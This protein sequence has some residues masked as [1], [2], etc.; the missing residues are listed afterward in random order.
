MNLRKYTLGLIAGATLLSGCGDDDIFGATLP[1]ATDNFTMFALTGNPPAYPAGLNTYFRQPVR[2]DGS[3]AF[4]VAFDLN[5]EGLVVIYPVKLVVSSLGGDRSVGIRKV[6]GQWNDVTIAPT[7]V[8]QTD[9]AVVASLGEV[10][11]IEANRGVG[12]DVCSF[13]LSPN[14]YTKLTVD[15][16]ALATRTISISTVVNPNCGFRSFEPGIPTR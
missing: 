2:V 4:D 6:P 1:T 10:V 8:Y 16:V 9:S 14:I 15:S 3:A 12:S 13:S 7:G 5:S 11:V